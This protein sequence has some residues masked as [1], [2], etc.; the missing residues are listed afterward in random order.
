MANRLLRNIAVTLGAAVADGIA[1]NRSLQ[2]TRPA[3]PTFSPIL[4]RL[5]QV[6]NRVT[7]FEILP[8]PIAAPSPEEIQALGTLFPVRV[9]R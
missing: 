6:E 5:E 3:P 2:V 9:K 4:T 7:H 1:R 8:A